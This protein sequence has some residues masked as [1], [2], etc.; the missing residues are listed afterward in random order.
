VDVVVSG[1]DL[2]GLALRLAPGQRVSGRFVFESRA[3]VARPSG[4]T[5]TLR[6]ATSRGLTVTAA[7]TAST[8]EGFT[9]SGV[10]PAPYRILATPAGWALKSAMLGGRDVADVPVEIR[11]GQD[12]SDLVL[13]FA[14]TPAEVSGTLYD[15]A[16]RPTSDLSLVFFAADRTM[17]FAGSRRVRLP[18]RPAG[19]GRFVF[20]G[21]V[22]GEYFLAAV[23]DV[24]PADLT[25]PVFLEEVSAAAIKIAI[26][27]GEKKTQDVRIAR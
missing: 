20:S 17:W 12:V 11:P 21:L 7:G 18:V 15:G 1:R 8:A 22:A 3:A 27:D 16:G 9:V 13:T 2:T 6:A 10:I 25:D 23:T 24:S 4:V 26:A 19:D 5:V 14:D